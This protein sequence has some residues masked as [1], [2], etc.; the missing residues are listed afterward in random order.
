MNPH[1]SDPAARAQP[2]LPQ[3][4]A[5]VGGSGSPLGGC[6]ESEDAEE[7]TYDPVP[8]K[9]TVTV[10]VRYRIGGRGQPLPYALDEGDVE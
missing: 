3:A 6:G 1:K 2:G 10:S 8:P 7:L 9:K 5:P 4:T